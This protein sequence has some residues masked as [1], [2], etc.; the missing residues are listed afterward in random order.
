MGVTFLYQQPLIIMKR[1]I[2]TLLATALCLAANAQRFSI[3]AGLFSGFT[4]AFTSDE[5]IKKDPRYEGRFEAKFA[6]VG[7]NIG[8]DYEQVGI[9]ISPGIINIGQNFYVTNTHGGQDGLRKIDLQYLNIPFA[10]KVHLVHFTAFKFSAMAT[11]SPAFLLGGDEYVSHRASR[12]TFPQNVIPLLP[13]DYLVEYDGVITP[14]VTRY[15][16][17]EKKDFKSLQLFTG[18]GF[19]T[20]WDASNHWRVSLD[21]RVYYGLLDSRTSAYTNQQE[22]TTSLYAMPGKRTDVFAHVTLGISRYIEME[23]GDRERQKKLKGSKNFRPTYHPSY[24]P[25]TQKPKHQ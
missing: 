21:F 12:L 18:A 8:L 20:D 13:A 2:V 22:A 3:S 1:M 19:R 15:N 25:G 4:T 23:L 9:M 6:P 16:I 10:F 14:D 5:G 11:V 24:R 7:L 17:G